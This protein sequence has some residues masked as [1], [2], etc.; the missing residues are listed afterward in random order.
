MRFDEHF[1]NNCFE[2]IKVIFFYIFLYF[3][4]MP[5][6]WNAVLFLFK[7]FLNQSSIFCISKEFFL[8]NPSEKRKKRLIQI[9]M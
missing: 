9:L 5:S 1:G 7:L 6:L 8:M 2:D 4:E 3:T